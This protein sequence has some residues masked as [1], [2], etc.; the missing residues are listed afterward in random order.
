MELGPFN[1][2]MI[3]H[4]FYAYFSASDHDDEDIDNEDTNCE[5]D[6]IPSSEDEDLDLHNPQT[7]KTH[8]PQIRK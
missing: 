6:A 1:L 5:D 8:T 2:I 4:Q 7:D 3:A